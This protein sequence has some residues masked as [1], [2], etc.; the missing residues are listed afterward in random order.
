M[1]RIVCIL[2]IALTSFMLFQVLPAAGQEEQKQ[3][4]WTG[5]LRDGKILTKNSLKN[6][7]ADHKKWLETNRKEG[8][9]AYLIRADL[10]GANLREADL[11]EADLRGADL[12][13]ANLRETNLRGANLSD[14]EMS[15][16]NMSGAYLSQARL[17]GANLS[18]ARLSATNLTQ[19]DLRGANLR[20]ADLSLRYRPRKLIGFRTDLRGA[21]LKEA[22]LK[23]CILDAYTRLPFIYEPKAGAHP[24]IPSIAELPNLSALTFKKSPHGLV[25]LREGFKKLGYRKQEREITYAIKHTQRRKLWNDEGGSSW[26]KAESLFYYIFFDITCKY[27][28]NPGRPLVLLIPLIIIFAI[29]YTIVLYSPP[30]KDGIWK[31]WIPERARKD[32]GA[33]DP[34]RLNL[35]LYSAIGFGFYFS[36]LSAFSIGWRELNVGNW[37]ARIQ[38]REYT[39]KATGWVRTISGLQ[40]LIS[41]YLLALWVL[42]YFGRPF[43]A[44]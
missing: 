24:Y 11:S 43:E 41:L 36:M 21:N 38:R 7:L 44:V 6:I 28:M 2:I 42:T 20:Q 30:E 17:S 27:G 22:D 35:K 10:R 33:K 5:K 31:A 29:P 19:A 23:D 3:K 9:R 25:D 16:A 1:I 12:S 39:L 34:H 26:N 13:G 32:L 4:E 37:I 18:Q 8:K 14:A 40:S 15:E